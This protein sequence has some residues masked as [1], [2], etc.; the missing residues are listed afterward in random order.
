MAMPLMML[1]GFVALA[2]APLFGNTTSTYT[3]EQTTPPTLAQAIVLLDKDGPSK[4]KGNPGDP[5]G[6]HSFDGPGQSPCGGPPPNPCGHHAFDGGDQSPCDDHHHPPVSPEP[7]PISTPVPLRQP[8]WS[9][10][11][12]DRLLVFTEP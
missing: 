4:P 2:G 6:Q 5:C 10:A 1:V 7:D 11:P 9:P 8:I 12:P 3:F